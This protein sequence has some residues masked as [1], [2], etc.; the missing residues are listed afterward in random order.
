M[1]LWAKTHSPTH[2]DDPELWQE[3]EV[4]RT[5][6]GAEAH[7]PNQ[8]IFVKAARASHAAHL[9]I[10]TVES[11]K[12]SDIAPTLNVNDNTGDTRATVAAITDPT[13]ATDTGCDCCPED[14][15]PDSARYRACGN[16]VT[17]S[18]IEWIGHR[19]L[20]AHKDND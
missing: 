1:T 3:T 18:V 14:P 20:A 8:A 16:A 13:N 17:V 11:W 15:K 5:L 10:G 4:S 7:R 2:D 12:D 19:L 6:T 9:D